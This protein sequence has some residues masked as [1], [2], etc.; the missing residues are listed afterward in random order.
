MHREF[1]VPIFSSL[2]LSHLTAAYAKNNWRCV[3]A[4]GDEA[5]REEEDERERERRRDFSCLLIALSTTVF[6]SLIFSGT[7]LVFQC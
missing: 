2:S 7:C 6:F 1:I 3:D 5:H 4:G